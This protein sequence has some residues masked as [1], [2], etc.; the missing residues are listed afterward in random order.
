MSEAA[1]GQPLPVIFL[2]DFGHQDEFTG[3]CRAV[4]DRIAPQVKVIDLTH[5]I[6]PGE[7]RQGAM[8]LASATAYSAP[9]IWLAVVDPGVGTERRA[10]VLQAG[11]HHFVGPDNGLLQLAAEAA[12]GVRRT[13]DISESPARLHPTRRTFHG[14]DIFSPVAARLALGE[15]PEGLGVEIEVDGLVGLE[16][17]P[18][19]VE[20]GM[21]EATVLAS[22]R[23]GNLYLNV[24]AGMID[25]SFLLPGMEVRIGGA[26]AADSGPGRQ[27]VFAGAFGDVA[28]GEAL[29]Y[30]DSS[31]RLSLAV[32]RGDASAVFGLGPDDRLSLR[33]A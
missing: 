30:P 10:V 11:P 22:D 12:G 2:T 1:A 28:E 7:I 17:P 33:P 3:V 21:I 24:G 29:L 6:E 18:A 14:R 8:A 13:W 23:Y 19:R 5:G 4:I 20:Q 31:G 32:N 27:A 26:G 16:L 9:A 25:E 15:D